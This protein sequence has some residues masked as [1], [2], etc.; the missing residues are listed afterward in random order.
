MK[1]QL[2]NYLGL[3]YEKGEEIEEDSEKAFYWYQK[4]AKNG[5][6]I[7]QVNVI[8][9]ELAFTKM[10]LKHLNVIKN[11]PKAS[12][13][14]E[15]INFENG[16]GTDINKENALEFYKFAAEKGHCDAQKAQEILL[17]KG[18]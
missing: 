18:V 10:K 15:N 6:N 12:I 1:N 16:I 9:T 3:L 4:A 5:H 17:A 13:Q 2:R 14:M 8:K 7:I 11:Q